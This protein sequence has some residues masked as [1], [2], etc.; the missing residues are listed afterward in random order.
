MI[1]KTRDAFGALEGRGR[2]A[3]LLAVGGCQDLL[4]RH[5]ANLTVMDRYTKSYFTRVVRYF[6]MQL[7]GRNIRTFY[8][9]DNAIRDD[10]LAA[11]LTLFDQAG[12]S[13]ATPR[14]DGKEWPSLS[15]RIRERMENIGH[16]AYIEP[17]GEVNHLEAAK[18]LARELECVA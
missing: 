12:I 17:D 18:T 10:R 6:F 11:V 3:M 4:Y 7:S 9:L 14:R 16:V 13:T 1:D 8:I 15:A 5:I 2:R